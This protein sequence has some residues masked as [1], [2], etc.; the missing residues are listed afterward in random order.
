MSSFVYLNSFVIFIVFLIY[1]IKNTFINENIF[2]I[3]IST[4]FLN[5][6]FWL[7]S[8]YM[9]GYYHEDDYINY[10]AGMSYVYLFM[11]Y[12]YRKYKGMY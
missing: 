1:S 3:I 7:Y 6:S 4:I 9:H 11:E 12:F 2:T 10:L 8:D 5:C